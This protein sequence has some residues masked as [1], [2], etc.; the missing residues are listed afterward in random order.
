MDGPPSES[1]ELELT[2]GARSGLAG[3]WLPCSKLFVV[4]ALAGVLPVD[5]LL[6]ELKFGGISSES[7][8]ECDGGGLDSVLV[9]RL[10]FDECEERPLT[11]PVVDALCREPRTLCCCVDEPPGA[12]G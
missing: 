10:E 8:D 4:L 11:A 5:A 12:V 9:S 2:D 7:F 3:A 6:L 1:L